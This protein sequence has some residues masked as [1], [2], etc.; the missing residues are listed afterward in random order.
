MEEEEILDCRFSIVNFKSEIIQNHKSHIRN[1]IRS[2]IHIPKSET[3]PERVS[4][5]HVLTFSLS[6]FVIPTAAEEFSPSEVLTP[7]DHV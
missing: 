3:C 2:E 5:S 4:H 7:Y 1:R 6:A